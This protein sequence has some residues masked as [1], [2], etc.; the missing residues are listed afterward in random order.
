MTMR[1]ALRKFALSAH[2]TAS[3]GWIGAVIAYLVL[4]IVVTTSQTPETLR[5]AYVAMDLTTSWAI[6]PLALTSLA[7][8]IVMTL[9]TKWGLWRH[10]WVII[11]LIL[12]ILAV[13]VLL[14]ETR[15]IS[16]LAQVA[17][18]P[19]TSNDELRALPGTLVHSGGGLVI[20]LVVNVLNIYKPRGMT[21]Y[22]QRKQHEDRTTVRRSRQDQQPAASV[23]QA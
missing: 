18:D 7:T 6:V 8:G 17:A 9:G 1:P 4:D 15:V 5:A 13:V 22:G 20:L 16:Y 23:S 3:V 19:S 2:L 21:R 12:T 11:S 10:Y 14:S